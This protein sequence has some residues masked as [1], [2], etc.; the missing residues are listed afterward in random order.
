MFIFKRWSSSSNTVSTPSRESKI[1]SLRS[2]DFGYSTAEQDDVLWDTFVETDLWSSVFD[3]RVDVILGPKGAGK[4]AV[5]SRLFSKSKELHRQGIE[6]VGAESVADDPVFRELPNVPTLT[7]KQFVALWKLY[8]LTL[9]G[10]KLRDLR[11]DDPKAEIVISALEA[12]ELLPRG[13]ESRLIELFQKALRYV[14]VE[15]EFEA[16]GSTLPLPIGVSGD[17]HVSGKVI[18]HPPTEDQRRQGLLSVHD[19]LLLAGDALARKNLTL[20]LLVDRL[21]MAF[22]SADDALEAKALRTL[23][24]TYIDL[25]V[26]R[27]RVSLKLFLRDDVWERITRVPGDP[28]IGADAIR[29]RS[30]R[31]SDNALINLAARRL[32]HNTD[33]CKIYHSNTTK[34]RKDFS[35]QQDL[36]NRVLP[37]GLSLT[38]EPN[39]TIIWLLEQLRDGAGAV[40]PRELVLLLIRAQEIQLDRFSLHIDSVDGQELFEHDTIKDAIRKVSEFRLFE[41]LCMEYPHLST[42]INLLR[43]ANIRQTIDDLSSTWR[44]SSEDSQRL[45]SQLVSVGFFQHMATM[46]RE[47]SFYVAPLYRH[48]LGMR[49]R[50]L[51]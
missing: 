32:A 30:I 44:R 29:R 11:I 47:S 14:Q 33:L 1:A 41:T 10:A 37:V 48:A 38:N 7:G 23:L 28:I 6:L 26:K 46:D 3:G 5:Y 15:L 24:Q 42:P 43:G 18:L 35:L 17:A 34:V 45:A 51:G 27:Y 36:I 25:L 16:G 12:S 4:S 22:P 49:D 31:W 9:I 13:G 20:W 8:F 40:A 50:G 21:D 19:L 2:A 39:S